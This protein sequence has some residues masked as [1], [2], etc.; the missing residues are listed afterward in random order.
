MKSITAPGVLTCFFLLAATDVGLRLCGYA[1]VR[2]FA[3]WV[4]RPAAAKPERALID[5]T[6]QRVLTATAFY[7]GRSQCLEQS[8]VCYVLLRRRGF[9]AELRIGVQPYPFSAHAWLE[10]DGAVVTEAPEYINRF[11]I[12]P[13]IRS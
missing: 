3:G 6:M 5:Q 9:N 12:M 7:P 1:R 2:R 4:G 13:D 11:A 10:I 8:L